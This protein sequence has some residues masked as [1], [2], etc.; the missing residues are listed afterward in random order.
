MV[1]QLLDDPVLKDKFILDSFVG[2]KLFTTEEGIG[3]GVF[4]HNDVIYRVCGT[5]LYSIIADGTHTQLGTIDGTDR[6]IF[7]AMNAD[8]IIVADRKAWV[9]NGTTLSQITDASLQSPDSV[10]VI[11]SQAIFDTNNDSF[12]VSNVGD[13][14]TIDPAN[15]AAAEYNADNLIRC[16]K[17]AQILFLFGQRT[18]EQ[19][20]NSGSGNPP[21]ARVENSTIEIGLGGLHAVNNNLNAV[22]FLGSDRRVYRILKGSYQAEPVS[23]NAL[24][25]EFS[26]YST[27]ADTQIECIDMNNQNFVV[28]TFPTANKT[29]VYLEGRSGQWFQWSSGTTYGRN[30]ANS[31]V[32]AFGKHYV[33]DYQNGN[34]YQIGFDCYVENDSPIIKQ[35]DSAPIAGDMI[36]HAGKR[37]F[38]NSLELD[39]EVGVGTNEGQGTNP[40]IMFSYS[41]DGGKT[42]SRE[43]WADLGKQG[44]FLTKVKWNSLGSFYTRIIRVKVS[45]PVYIAIKDAIAEIEIGI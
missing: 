8:L 25:R 13:A 30:V 2:Q 21:F 29:W 41:D 37:I 5:K 1:P 40:K 42:F 18:V 43:R 15:S 39:M 12:V 34:I 14:S 32:A 22:Y 36:G 19:W 11:N 20:W 35:R 7:D 3:R 45:D 6:V 26:G 4:F 38:M 24:V 27:I 9:W 28:L 44:Q 17:F 33:E 16:Y 23:N 10:C 31:Y